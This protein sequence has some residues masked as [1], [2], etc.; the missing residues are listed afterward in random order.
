MYISI[1]GLIGSGKTT[2]ATKLSEALNLPVYYEPVVDNVYLKDFYANPAKY[3][4]P[5][6]V[7][8][9]SK[10]FS[11]QQQ[12]I[13]SGKGGV[14]DRTIYEDGI[15][16]G[17]LRDSGLMEQRD[18]ETY[19]ALFEQMSHLMA[20]PSVI[21]HLDISAE[22]SLRRIQLRD[23]ECEKSITLEYLQQ[24][25]TAYDSFIERISHQIPVIKLEYNE[26]I[27]TEKIV[28]LIKETF[29]IKLI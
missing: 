8:L 19:Q 26:F 16:A 14:Q 24:L 15:F 2:L 18:Y 28:D 20:R 13:W 23:R 3:S 1:S 21:I 11:Q 17:V 27:A 5:L 4:F 7:Y 10:R 9:L 12:I 25:K 22:E 29:H 6:Q